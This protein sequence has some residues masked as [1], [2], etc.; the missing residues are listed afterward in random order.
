MI[1]TMLGAGRPLRVAAAITPHGFGHAA[2]TLAVLDA[3][4]RLVP[5]GI[6][7]TF[8]TRVPDSVLKGR[9]GRP[10]TVVP[11]AA[12]TDFGMVM[13][14]S[15]GVLVAESIAAY[16]AAHDRW[17]AVVAEEGAAL[18]AARPD[19]VVSCISYAA[20]EAA[21]RLGVPGIGLGPFTWREILDAYA[22]AAPQ[23]APVLAAMRGAYAGAEAMLATTP[24]VH[25][26]YAARRLVGPVGKPGRRRRAEL[27]AG[28]GAAAGERLAL[29]ALGGIAEDVPV[30]RWPTVP[31]W[32]YIEPAEVLAAGLSVSEAIASCDAVVTKPGY[33]TFVEAAC[34]G[35]P[36]L[37]R[38][39]PD[40]PETAG[41]AA[42]AAR[43][44]PCFDV[45]I[46]TFSVGA[47]GDHLQ[48][49]LQEERNPLGYPEGNR[50]AAEIIVEIVTGRRAP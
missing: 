26:D 22:G 43:Y 16:A 1:P 7:V 2:I 3:L 47:L 37:Y 31:G 39:R 17:D 25:M 18:A 10:C 30:A 36:L 35:V 8:L 50:E 34:A 9:W 24:A 42:W 20:L 38:A 11:H 49:V 33:G 27:M 32:R 48:T 19:V 15:T 4:H 23:A 6:D 44:V 12:A 46:E 41:M 40:W 45:D 21:R 29:V 13:A 5:T 14:S 28:L